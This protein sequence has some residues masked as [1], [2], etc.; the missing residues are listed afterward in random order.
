MEAGDVAVALDGSG[1][2]PRSAVAEEGVEGYRAGG[3][4]PVHVGDELGAWRVVRKLG[5]GHFSTVW[6][7]R[8]R[9]G[10]GEK[11]VHAALKVQK[12]AEHYRDAARDEVE[13]LRTLAGNADASR[14]EGRG[15][16]VRL[17]DDFDV[18]GPNGTHPVMAFELLC[19]NLLTWLDHWPRGVPMPLV[20]QLAYQITAGLSFLHESGIIHTD[21]KPEN[22]LV[23]GVRGH[24]CAQL[25]K[26]MPSLDAVRE[27]RGTTTRVVSQVDALQRQV[28]ALRESLVAGSKHSQRRMRQKLRVAQERLEAVRALAS[29]AAATTITSTSTNTTTSSNTREEDGVEEEFNAEG[30]E[31]SGWSVVTP[32]RRFKRNGASKAGEATTRLVRS[33]GAG[34]CADLWL[35][36]FGPAATAAANAPTNENQTTLLEAIP[37]ACF[38]ADSDDNEKKQGTAVALMVGSIPEISTHVGL[39][40][41]D[42]SSSG[43]G[44][45]GVCLTLKLG[46]GSIANVTLDPLA[47][48]QPVERDWMG[49]ALAQFVSRGQEGVDPSARGP[50]AAT[51]PKKDKK[52]GRGG[53]HSTDGHQNGNGNAG[54]AAPAHPPLHQVICVRVVV[55]PSQPQAT[56]HVLA[57]LEER[58]EVRFLT[59]GPGGSWLEP[60][61][62]ATTSA[63]PGTKSKPK[64]KPEP[65][66]PMPTPTT[67]PRM[68]GVPVS[69]LSV[70]TRPLPERLGLAVS[71]TSAS[72]TNQTITDEFVGVDPTHVFLDPFRFD[73]VVKIVDLGNACWTDR[74]FTEDIQTRQYRSPEVILGAGFDETADV[75]SLAC[76]LFEMLTGELLFDPR[77]SKR[78]CRDEAHMALVTELIGPIVPHGLRLLRTGT[79]VWRCFK[80][81][82]S[83]RV[84]TD[85]EY[86]NLE[87]LLRDTYRFKPSV[88]SDVS[89]FLLPMLTWEPRS[90]ASAASMLR[91]PFLSAFAGSSSSS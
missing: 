66:A 75:W 44:G 80:P 77:S 21:L 5:W 47:S 57:F 65:T 64:P 52:R 24:L 69:A 6:L 83:L 68:L 23:A 29:S 15:L 11:G 10:E 86:C 49:S 19:D 3:Y 37:T 25:R 91:H 32:S 78:F 72:S 40:D 48:A 74:H 71:P 54:G 27:V 88:A 31:E 42:T 28:D 43:G 81:D 41:P 50:A 59:R 89:R 79:R 4:H 12:S 22:V 56:L 18:E 58:F 8:R 34:A 36:N 16:V 30:E 45:G 70:P 87:C 1:K 13:I 17:L 7:G 85:L 39:A 35:R 90:R 63:A 20:K 55:D 53:R 82:G 60:C 33:L 67:T 26:D 61:A 51:T 2:A 14:S 76:M 46:D 62:P 84:I 9:E 73:V 38:P